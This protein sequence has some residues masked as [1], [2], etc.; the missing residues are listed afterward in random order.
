MHPE[1]PEVVFF[2]PEF[3]RVDVERGSSLQSS[4]RT[5]WTKPLPKDRAVGKRIGKKEI[6]EFSSLKL[7]DTQ[8]QGS[9]LKTNMT[10]A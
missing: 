9:P 7:T 4:A 5:P 8:K 1:D 3:R 2:P 6:N 10:H